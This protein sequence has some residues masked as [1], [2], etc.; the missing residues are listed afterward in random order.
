MVSRHHR[1]TPSCSEASSA[2]P[3]S[4]R[5]THGRLGVGQRPARRP[6]PSRA[7]SASWR[8]MSRETT[9]VDARR[10]RRHRVHRERRRRWR[11]GT[12]S[13]S[14][15]SAP[16]TL[17]T[18]PVSRPS[19]S[20]ATAGSAPSGAVES[21]TASAA[22]RSPAA[23]DRQPRS[24]SASSR[25]RGGDDRAG[26]E[27]HRGGGAAQLLQDHRGLARRG[28][29]AAAL[30]GHQQPG[31]AQVGGQGLPQPGRRAS[32][33]RRTRRSPRRDRSGRRAGRAR[34]RAGRPRRR[35]RAGRVSL[36]AASS[37]HGTSLSTRGSAGRPRTR[38]ATM[39]RR[40]SEV[41]PS[42]ELPLARR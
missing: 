2:A 37:F 41:P 35:C 36:I 26:E 28:A 14:A 39:L 15:S 13:T 34:W 1:A 12:S 19:A 42:M 38:S 8:V 40:I 20:T 30:L 31:Q 21:G 27:R 4:Q 24:P 18:V 7:T 32:G 25:T 33:R 11:P 29:G 16:A 10:G 17:V 9:G 23:S 5:P 6:T 22:V 3:A